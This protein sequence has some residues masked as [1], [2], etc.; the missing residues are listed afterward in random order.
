MW[1]RTRVPY[2]LLSP[3]GA[4]LLGF[5]L[6]G[7]LLAGPAAAA[8]FN[9]NVLDPPAEGFLDTTAAAPVGGNPGVTL[10]DQRLNALEYAA[11]IWGALLTSSEDIEIDAIFATGACSGGSFAYAAAFSNSVHRDFVGALQAD[12]WYPQALANRLAAADLSLA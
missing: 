2:R 6:A 10:G 7:L 1:Q 9:I 12:T 11:G 3:L 4:G 8:T 5:A